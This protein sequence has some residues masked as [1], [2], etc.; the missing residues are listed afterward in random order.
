MNVEIDAVF[1]KYQRCQRGRSIFRTLKIKQGLI[2]FATGS[3][4]TARFGSTGCLNYYHKD[5][6]ALISVLCVFLTGTIRGFQNSTLVSISFFAIFS[7]LSQ[8]QLSKAL[9]ARD[10]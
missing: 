7:P 3:S 8:L 4:K 6:E 9:E 10:Q 1:A 2:K 5:I